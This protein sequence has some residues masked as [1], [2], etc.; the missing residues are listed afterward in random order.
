MV[1]ARINEIRTISSLPRIEVDSILSKSAS[2]HA[3]YLVINNKF[4]REEDSRDQYFTGATLEER[5]NNLGYK[6]KSR[7]MF[8]QTEDVLDAVDLL[9]NTVYHRLRL[10]DPDLKYFGYGTYKLKDKTIHVFDFGYLNDEEEKLNWDMIIYPANNSTEITTGWSGEE[11]PD[12]FPYGTQKP[13]GVPITIIFKDKINS[14]SSTEL[15]DENGNKINS[16]VITPLNDINNKNFNAII[17]VPKETLKDNF[18]YII[19]IKVNL[20]EDKV[21]KDYNWSFITGTKK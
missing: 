11:K 20:G 16:F 19:N 15:I 8:C 14:V 18:R 1:I 3:K 21:D 17:I 5:L 12:P 10:L 2:N 7:E 9:L 6:R 13:L 4:D